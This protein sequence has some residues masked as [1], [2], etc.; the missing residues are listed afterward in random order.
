[1]AGRIATLD[2][3]SIIVRHKIITPFALTKFI[4]YAFLA[5]SPNIIRKVF[6][7]LPIVAIV[8]YK[9]MIISTST[10]VIKNTNVDTIENI[11]LDVASITHKRNG[12]ADGIRSAHC[13]ILSKNR[14]LG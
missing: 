2:I 8:T 13:R 10:A 12:S 1:V 4:V 11:V 3:T 7:M 5:D 14:E 9:S 6:C